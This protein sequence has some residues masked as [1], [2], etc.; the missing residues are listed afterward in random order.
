[1][2]LDRS[3]VRRDCVV[4][5]AVLLALTTA[6]LAQGGEGETNRKGA[7]PA[8]VARW[9]QMRFGMFIH[10]GPVTLKG[11]GISWS[12][13]YQVPIEEYDNLYKRFNP[14][15]FNGQQW[16]KAAKEAGMKYVVLTT[17]HHDGFCL[18]DTKQTDYNIMHTPFGRDA[19]KELAEACRKE[20][21]RFG[22]YYSTCDWH[23][24]DFPLGCGTGQGVGQ[25][26]HP[27]LDRY[28][29]YLRKQVAELVANYGP[30]VTVWF[31][32]PQLFDAKRGQGVIDF[33][34]S[35]HPDILINN[36]TGAAGDYDTPEGII[37]KMQIDRPWETC[38]TI[39]T[40]WSWRPNDIMKSLPECLQTLV[41][42]V[43]RDGN[44]LL[45]VGPTSD[46]QIEPRQVERLRE[47]GQW[48]AKYGESVYGTRGGPFVGTEPFVGSD[49]G[50]ATYKDNVIYLHILDRAIDALKLPAIEKKIIGHS[51][52][53]G[54]TATVKQSGDSIEVSVPMCDRQEI[55]TI[56]VL[57]LDGPAADAKPRYKK[58]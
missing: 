43:C 25:K 19:T 14:V 29:Q 50:G 51:V 30:L 17:K 9:R 41:R 31:D 15:K 16:A 55:D 22:A 56:V 34:R 13:G 52:L 32:M 42:V 26:P 8:A 3:T 11:T 18:F 27:N 35:L 6:A 38:M 4:F 20:G 48:L 12:R 1:M 33:V 24:P 45:N 39:C 5:A 36:R 47:M 44:L 28:E 54:G 2:S 57:K 10:W 46:G 21:I 23:H 49:W 7:D 53:T 40:D 58:H 37:G